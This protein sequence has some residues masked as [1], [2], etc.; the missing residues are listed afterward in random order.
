MCN[1]CTSL[2]I[3]CLA[4]LLSAGFTATLADDAQAADSAAGKSPS[5][6]AH[7]SADQLALMLDDFGEASLRAAL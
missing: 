3:E 4:L 7:Q 6:A 5:P 2:A 1:V